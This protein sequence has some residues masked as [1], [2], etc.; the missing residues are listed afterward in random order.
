[1][2]SRDIEVTLPDRDYVLNFGANSACRLEEALH[3][4]RTYGDVVD[5]LNKTA[6]PS[7]SLIRAFVKASLVDPADRDKPADL[8]DAQVGTFIDNIGGWGMV[9]R[10]LKADQAGEEPTVP[11]DPPADPPPL[12]AVPLAMPA[13]P[14]PGAAERR[15]KTPR[16]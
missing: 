11:A 10:W 4:D 12:P 16:G 8:T 1:V 9:L 2:A 14:V 7:V 6:R 3:D 13:T 15:R 5:A